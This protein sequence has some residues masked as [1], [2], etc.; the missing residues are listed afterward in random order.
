MLQLDS[1]RAIAIGLV[2]IEHLGGPVVREHFPLSAG[3]LGVDLFF[4]LSGFLISGNLFALLEEKAARSSAVLGVFF[5]RRAVRLVPPYYAILA[6]LWLTD[7]FQMRETWPWH[8]LY[9][10]NFLVGPEGPQQHFW[11]LAVEEQ[12]YLLLPL[13]LLGLPL[14]RRT[15][16]GAGLVAVGLLSRCFVLMADLPWAPFEASLPGKLEVLGGGVL[17]GALC[18]RDGRRVFDLLD[19]PVGWL[20]AAAAAVALAT[21]LTVFYLL[22]IDGVV[23]YLTFTLTGA[24]Y[25]GWLV[26][27]AARGFSGLLGRIFNHKALR[28]VGRISY[29]LYLVHPVAPKLLELPAVAA[30]TGPLP[31]P[32]LGIAS[33][34]LSILVAALSW[35]LLERP[36]VGWGR[37]FLR[38][39]QGGGMREVTAGVGSTLAERLT[40]AER[41]P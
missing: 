36:V 32:V 26:V 40:I 29:T 39:R 27:F 6:L 8:T 28:Y 3:A 22:P 17:L 9:A 5:F 14:R 12:F 7:L 10:S 4:V 23:R 1:V 11:S 25:L 18:Y 15:V 19:G 2:I 30:V 37:Q 33:L 21:E 16:A 31:R 34:A 24:I 13:V 41:G 38:S 35:N 20:F